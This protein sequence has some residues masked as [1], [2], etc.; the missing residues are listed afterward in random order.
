MFDAL[1]AKTPKKFIAVINYT[2]EIVWNEEDEIKR[3]YWGDFDSFLRYESSLC[4]LEGVAL[5]PHHGA[6]RLVFNYRTKERW[7]ESAY[8]SNFMLYPFWNFWNH[9][10]SGYLKGDF[11]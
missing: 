1:V 3:V 9:S 7:N 6:V 11:F 4:D 10:K 8:K 5:Y 2:S